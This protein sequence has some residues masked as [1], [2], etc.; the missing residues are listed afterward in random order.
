MSSK[1][2]SRRRARI[3]A[4]QVLYQWQLTQNAPQD[5]IQ[6]FVDEHD[7][8]NVDVSYFS[9]LVTGALEKIDEIDVVMR[10]YLDRDITE[11]NPVELS[12]LRV[13]FYEFI[14]RPDIPYRVVINEAMEVAKKY[15]A[16]QG[17]KYVNGVLDAAAVTLRA[18]ERQKG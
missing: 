8:K 5:M 13:G 1:K 9:G 15:G 12:I 16:E 3:Y 4:M 17:H 7:M 11:L 6:Q 18:V 14:Y 10:E 2:P